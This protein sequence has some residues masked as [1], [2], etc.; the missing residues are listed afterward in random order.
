M[1]YIILETKETIGLSQELNIA[2]AI[3]QNYPIL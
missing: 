1:S 2:E 3:S